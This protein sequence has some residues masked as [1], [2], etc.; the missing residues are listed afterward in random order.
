MPAAERRGRGR[1][2]L[3]PRLP[4]ELVEGPRVLALQGDEVDVLLSKRSHSQ[5]EDVSVEGVV[6]F[7]LVRVLPPLGQLPQRVRQVVAQ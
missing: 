6:S 4:A 2:V 7:I 5:E 3:G 1:Q